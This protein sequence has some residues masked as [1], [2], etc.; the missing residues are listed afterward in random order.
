M[1]DDDCETDYKPKCLMRDCLRA[2]E[3]PLGAA[4]KITDVMCVICKE[5]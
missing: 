3:R 1:I 2:T 5:E 4:W